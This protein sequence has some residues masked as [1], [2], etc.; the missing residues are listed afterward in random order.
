MV[1]FGGY[2]NGTSIQQDLYDLTIGAVGPQGET[3]PAGPQ[4]DAGIIGLIG[5]TGATG[6]TG[7]VGPQGIQGETGL[8]G[9]TGPQGEV[10]PQGETGLTGDMG[11][12][13]DVGPQG[14]QGETGLTGDTGPQGEVGP[15]GIQ[16]ETGLTGD[17]GPQGSQGDTGL[18]GDVGPMGLIGLPGPMGPQG[19]QGETGATGEQGP[20]GPEGPEGSF[21]RVNLPFSSDQTIGSGGIKFIGLGDT[22]GSHAVTALPLA[23]SGYVTNL[24]VRT[25]AAFLDDEDKIRFEVWLE[26]TDG[27]A[28]Y[29]SGLFCEITKTSFNGKGCKVRTEPGDEA[30]LAVE[31]MYSISVRVINGPDQIP[32]GSIDWDGIQT[33]VSA[34][35]GI[36]T[37]ELISAQ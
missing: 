4:G 8:T 24:V 35:V 2:E 29:F 19:N 34:L 7:E 33:S 9:D 16:G 27:S 21:D 23:Y 13:G 30:L 14:V 12:Q 22:S 1:D 5:L 15:Q 3:G 6:L 10:G 36:A 17:S 25:S 20:A 31:E 28:P 18:T 11:P 26:K 32:D 37:G